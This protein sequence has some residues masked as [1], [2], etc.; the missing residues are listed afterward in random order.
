MAKYHFSINQFNEIKSLLKRRLHETRDEQKKTRARIRKLGFNIS[1]YFNGFSDQDFQCLLDKGIISIVGSP[2]TLYSE[3]KIAV[4]ANGSLENKSYEKEALPPIADTDTEILILG[5]LPSDNSLVNQQYYNN[6]R[7]QFWKIIFSI[8]NDGLVIENYD[9]RIGLLKRHKIGLWDVL[10]SCD[11]EGS[12]D[13]AIKNP[14]AND[15]KTFFDKHTKIKT[16]IFNGKDS[17][18]FYRQFINFNFEKSLVQL[19]STSSLNTHQKIDQK[20]EEWDRH[21]RK[22]DR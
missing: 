16:L 10:K 15:F 19:N 8:F 17:F 6:P 2:N 20:T 22:T 7:N 21:L 1:D 9:N 4:S 14:I 3:Q 13:A 18:S 12:S 11:R 5:T